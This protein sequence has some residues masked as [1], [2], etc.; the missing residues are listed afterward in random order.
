MTFIPYEDVP[1]YL[2][3]DGQEG[4]YIFAESASI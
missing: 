2:A 4:E 3:L 1:L